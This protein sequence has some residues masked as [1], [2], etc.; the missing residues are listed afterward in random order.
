[1]ILTLLQTQYFA[2]GKVDKEQVASYAKRKGW[3]MKEAGRW[4]ASVL[5]Y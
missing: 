1:M 4:L 2:S 5:S 3:T